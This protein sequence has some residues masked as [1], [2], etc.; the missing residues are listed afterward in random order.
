MFSKLFEI[1]I[2]IF[3]KLP[4]LF[5]YIRDIIWENLANGGAYSVFL[6]QPIPNINIHSLFLNCADSEKS[7]FCRCSFVQKCPGSDQ[8]PNRMFDV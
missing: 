7:V 4:N 5:I 6:D 2:F 1:P 3:Q 8:I